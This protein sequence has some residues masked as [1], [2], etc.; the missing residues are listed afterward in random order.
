MGLVTSLSKF[1]I[2]LYNTM[3]IQANVLEV[4]RKMAT[5]SFNPTT[6]D[7]HTWFDECCFYFLPPEKRLCTSISN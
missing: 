1:F 3:I 2:W 5:N 6:C 4:G 7:V